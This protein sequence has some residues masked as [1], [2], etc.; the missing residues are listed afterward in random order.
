MNTETPIRIIHTSFYGQ[1][2]REILA[3]LLKM[4]QSDIARAKNTFKIRSMKEICFGLGDDNE[5]QFQVFNKNG[6]RWKGA[7][8]GWT[9]ARTLEHIAWVFKNIV[10]RELARHSPDAAW[11][12]NCKA[13]ITVIDIDFT[14]EEFYCIYDSLRARKNADK[15]YDSKLVEEL[16]GTPLDPIMTEMK[17]AQREEIANIEK[18][19]ENEVQRLEH[20]RWTEIE[21]MRKNIVDEYNKKVTAAR[22][23][24]KQKI[25][26][27]SASMEALTMSA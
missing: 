8:N 27:L 1:R 14:V 9:D 10:V 17:I 16:R 18:E 13:K 2:A 11:K 22:E 19:L 23:A 5:C 4:S 6:W 24:A 7:F 21:K 3:A 12:R 15:R 20:E 25:A 26:E